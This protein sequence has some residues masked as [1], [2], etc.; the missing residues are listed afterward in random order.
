LNLSFNLISDITPIEE[1]TFLEKLHLN[2]NKISVIDSLQKL[3]RLQCLGLF[4]NEI[5]NAQKS[6]EIIADLAINFKLKELSIEGNPI[7]STVKF[8]N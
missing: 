7:T 8:R 1:L 3:T 6:L 5:Y 2:R 4:H